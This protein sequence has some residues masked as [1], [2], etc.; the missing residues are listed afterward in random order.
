[1]VCCFDRAMSV[2]FSVDIYQD[3]VFCNLR[4][5]QQEQFKEMLCLEQSHHIHS[6]TIKIIS[7]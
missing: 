6:S 4:C 5:R 1:M 3:V 7:D 2:Y